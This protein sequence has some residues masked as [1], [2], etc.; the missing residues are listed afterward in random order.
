MLSQSNTNAAIV[1]ERKTQEL[2]RNRGK[3]MNRNK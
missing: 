1:N 3:S 2:A